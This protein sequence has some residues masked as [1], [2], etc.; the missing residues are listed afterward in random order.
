V[1]FLFSLLLGT[2]GVGAVEILRFYAFW[3]I[4]LLPLTVL[5]APALLWIAATLAIACPAIKILFDNANLF[6]MGMKDMM[7][8]EQLSGFGIVLHPEAWGPYIQ[9][10]VFGSGSTSQDTIAILPFLVLGLALGR[11]DLTSHV[12]RLRLIGGGAA[13]SITALVMGTISPTIVG[14]AQAFAAAQV[15]W[16]SLVSTANPGPA[17]PLYSA[18]DCFLV[19]GLIAAL[20]GAL[21]MLMERPRFTRIL[22][23]IAAFGSM[24]LTWYCLH[25]LVIGKATPLGFITT[26][27]VLSYVLFVVAALILSVI[28]R[29]FF[30]RGPLEW[31]QHTAVTALTS[32]PTSL[33]AAGSS[34]ARTD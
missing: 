16:Q 2:L 19:A 15:P 26:G 20:L 7:L 33:H 1:L 12:T 17:N 25:L 9:N 8:L 22:W 13:V 28:W 21:L 5:K 4:I 3:L 24:S 27:S 10:I 34:T 14:S 6:G 31:I 29:R 30:T 11:M 23:P 18:V 32:P